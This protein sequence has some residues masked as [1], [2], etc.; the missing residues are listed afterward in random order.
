L[1]QPRTM[2]S[3]FHSFFGMRGSIVHK[4]Q[5]IYEVLL[6][7]FVQIEYIHCTMPI[8]LYIFEDNWMCREALATV[9]GRETGIEI[10]GSAGT[11]E[12]GMAE[13]LRI[14]PD[15]VL[16]DIRFNGEDRGIQ[17]TRGLKGELPET[18][19]IIFTEFNDEGKLRE[20]IKAGA[21]GFLLKS[22]I[23]NPETLTRAIRTV[24]LGDAFMTPSITEK[25]IKE[26]RRLPE[27]NLFDLTCRERQI[28]KLMA[29]GDDNRG[30]AGALGI[31]LRTVANH[32]SNILFKMNARNR[33]E[34]AAIARREGILD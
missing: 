12:E 2:G 33:T 10:S 34:A 6:M 30:I 13:V 1:K 14:I 27:E 31:E 19:V 8:K 17:A 4:Y 3:G 24:Y 20:A 32:V 22:E 26:I 9:L 29:A 16:M 5:G 18:K 15:V 21:S 11:V 25:V 28:L 23:Q 7:T